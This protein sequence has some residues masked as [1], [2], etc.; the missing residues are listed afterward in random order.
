MNIVKQTVF[1]P[2]LQV[3]PTIILKGAQ[4]N[5]KVK[6]KAFLI[7]ILSAIGFAGYTVAGY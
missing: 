5:L 3:K 1:C 2:A 7:L 6:W 4:K